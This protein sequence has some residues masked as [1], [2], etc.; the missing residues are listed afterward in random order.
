M[1]GN[2]YTNLPTCGSNIVIHD[3]CF[4][5]RVRWSFEQVA[6]EKCLCWNPVPTMKDITVLT[7]KVDYSAE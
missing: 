7:I 5:G 1:E 4:R 3:K 2:Q 6:N